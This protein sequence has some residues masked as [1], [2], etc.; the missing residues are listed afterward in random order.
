M[1]LLHPLSQSARHFVFFDRSGRRWPLLRR[2]G[3]G[4]GGLGLLA[5]AVFVGSLLVDPALTS[6]L[7]VMKREIRGLRR[8]ITAPTVPQVP[9][10]QQYAKA[11]ATHTAARLEARPLSRGGGEIR[12]ARYS[13]GD[14]RSWNSLQAHA[15]TLTHVAAATLFMTTVGGEIH[16]QSD[17]RLGEF[18]RENR[19]AHLATLRNLGTSGWVPEAVEYLAFGPSSHREIFF[20]ELIES[21]RSVHAQ[22]VLV[23]WQGIDPTYQAELTALLAGMANAL[24]KGG[25]ELWLSISVGDDLQAF[26]LPKLSGVVDRFV[27]VLH[28]ENGQEDDPGPIASRNWFEGWLQALVGG[29]DPSQWVIEL[30]AYG[31]DWSG[32]SRVAEEISF[33]DAMA[34]ARSSGAGDVKVGAPDYSPAFSYEEAGTSHTVWFLDAATFANQL[35]AVG[36][37]GTAGVSIDRLGWEDP[38]IWRVLEAGHDRR[39]DR[40]VLESLGHITSEN[41][42]V[43][44]G[45]G[46]VVTVDGLNQT[47][48]RRSVRRLTDDL[49]EAEYEEFPVYPTLSHYGSGGEGKVAITFDDGPDP[50]WTPRILDILRRH[51]VK[52]TFFVTGANAEKHP[53]LLRRILNEGHEVGSH[54]FTHANLA[55]VSGHQVELELNATQRVIEAATGRSTRLFRPP[56]DADSRPEDPV[57]LRAI[58][59]AQALGYLTVLEQIDP[60]DWARPGVS[61]ILRRVRDQRGKGSLI[62]LHDA[63]GDRSQTVEVLP[64]LLEALTQRGDRVV[65]LAELL[66]TTRDELMPPVAAGKEQSCIVVISALGFTLL[67]YFQ[68]AVGIF[69]VTATVLVAV[70]TLLIVIL[71]CLH[72]RRQPLAVEKFPPLGV[73]IPAFREE[74]VIAATLRALRS[75]DY[76]SP[77][78]ILVV[79][80]GSPDATAE[81]VERIAEEDGRVKLLK[82]PNAGKAAALENGIN[83]LNQEILIFLDADTQFRPDTLRHLI[84]PLADA[85]VGAVAGHPRVGNPRTLVACCQDLEYI[86]GFNLERRALS[87]WN[88]VTVVPGAVSAFRRQ[89]IVESGG[90]RHDTLAEDTDLTL[91]IHEAGWRVECAP[92]AIAYTEA[93]ESVGTLVKQRFRWAL[94]TMQC[95]W[96]HRRQHFSTRNPALGWF[97]LPGIWLFQVLLVASAPFIDVLFLQSALLGRWGAVLPYFSVFLISDLVLA[98]VACRMESVKWTQALWVLPMRFLYRPVLSFVIW[99]AIVAAL[100]GAW[101]GWGKLERTGAVS[102]AAMP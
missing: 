97:S 24:H 49:L 90:F 68:N 94:G 55:E 42:I 47:D 11:H 58:R 50:E 56:Y 53:A 34:R 62:L 75:S 78:E 96:K 18:L 77:I 84:V 32:N 67:R 73:V 2:V 64:R 36:R 98:V 72:G 43:H 1:S 19:L 85:R 44:L 101:V 81:V 83:T 74:K 8:Q 91:A 79:D 37:Y 99:R 30:G 70:R 28:D 40:G 10:W 46:E 61:E 26:D 16:T 39:W 7:T 52:A 57:H 41:R 59:L 65:S 87:Q 100:R 31:Y 12:L 29:L 76:P 95:V 51:Q 13:L 48:G 14:E 22:G 71:A 82:Q 63:G 6:P 3:V 102:P 89:A 23:D 38:G 54:T 69:V 9:L 33:A 20:R 4:L 21:L 86:M 25:F 15:R 60:Q 88:A 35:R 66:G 5:G 45:A 80:D 27:A 93:P 92:G 17:D